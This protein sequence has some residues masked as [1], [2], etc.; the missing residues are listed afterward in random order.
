MKNMLLILVL[1]VLSVPAL[2]QIYEQQYDRILAPMERVVGEHNNEYANVAI[3][4]AEDDLK[5]QAVRYDEMVNSVNEANERHF[6]ELVNTTILGE[7]K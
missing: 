5:D 2:A 4:G 1:L 6:N 3:P 7:K